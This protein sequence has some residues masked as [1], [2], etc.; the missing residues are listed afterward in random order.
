MR[1]PVEFTFLFHAAVSAGHHDFVIKLWERSLRDVFTWKTGE[2]MDVGAAMLVE[3]AK[4]HVALATGSG[5]RTASDGSDATSPTSAA[6]VLLRLLREWFPIRAAGGDQGD[7]TPS[8]FEYSFFSPPAQLLGLC[9][10][11][12]DVLWQ[13]HNRPPFVLTL[14]VSS[15]AVRAWKNKMWRPWTKLWSTY[16][17]AGFVLGLWRL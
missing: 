11:C 8:A 4:A 14:C 9:I 1:A 16:G 15:I 3:V 12:V 5:S 7:N 2:L 6:S 17:E 10:E 13:Q